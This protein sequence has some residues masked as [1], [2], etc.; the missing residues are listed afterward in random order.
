MS[1]EACPRVVCLCG[2]LRLAPLFL[3]ERRRLTALGVIVLAPESAGDEVTAE[4]RAALG[5]LHRRRIDM[6][7]EVRVVS[8]GGYLGAATRREIEYA[9]SRGKVLSAVEPGLGLPDVS[10]TGPPAGTGPDADVVEELIGL[11]PLTHRLPSGSDRRAIEALLDEDFAEIGASGRRYSR[12]HVI[13]VVEGRY[14]EGVEPDD[15]TWSMRNLAALR[16]AEDLCL[17]TYD[18]DVDERR[19]RRTTLWRRRDGAWR[20]LHHQGTLCAPETAP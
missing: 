19:S 18:L 9:L 12:D 4:E 20:A 16:V 10:R 6:A 7:D 13:D 2:S 1:S 11:E 8:E 3:S 15:G 14:A 5:E 17:L